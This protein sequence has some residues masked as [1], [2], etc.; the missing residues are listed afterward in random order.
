MEKMCRSNN[1]DDIF[2]PIIFLHHTHK[3]IAS[4]AEMREKEGRNKIESNE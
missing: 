1:D 2:R 4:H 3:I